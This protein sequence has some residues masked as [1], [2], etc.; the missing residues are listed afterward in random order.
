MQETMKISENGEQVDPV[1]GM[2]VDETSLHHHRHNGVDYYFCCNGC[3]EKF[4][5]DPVYYLSGAANEPQVAIPGATYICPMC[6]EVEASEP[7]SCPICG[8]ALEPD[9]AALPEM[10]TE[11]TC[12]MHPEVI[13]E[14]AGDCPICGM[15]LEARQVTVEEKN[16]ELNDMN[17]RFRVGLVL[18]LPLFLLA[19]IAD[20]APSLLPQSL[21][22]QPGQWIQFL[23]A[24]PVVLWCGLPFFER[25]WQSLKTGYYNMFTLIAIGVG[26]A[27][28]YSLFALL[29]PDLMPAALLMANGTAPVYF[30]AAAV[31]TTLVLL[32]QVLELKAR[33]QT[34]KAIRQLLGLAPAT[35]QVLLADGSEK[36][37]P[38]A[39]VG[40]GDVLRVKPGNKIPVDGN[41]TEGNSSVDES[42]ISG[43]ALPVAKTIGDS[44]IGATVNGSGSL[45]I[46]AERVGAETLL[47]QIVQM[48]SEAQRSRAPIQ[49]LADQVAAYFVPTV[50]AISV[51]TLITWALLG[52]EP[53]FSYAI[54]NAVAV[55]IIACP[56]A[57]GLAT[58]MS[59]MVGTGKGA[60]IGVLVKNAESLE[61]LQR[62]DTLVIDKTG[63]LTEGR[64]R[65]VSLQS[66]DN[67]DEDRLL[68]LAASLERASEHPLA[69][70]IVQSATDRGL[71]L[72]AVDNFESIAGR[73]VTGIVDGNTVAVGNPALMQA[74]SID[75]STILADVESGQSQGHTVMVIAI[76]DQIGGIVAMADTIKPSARP[77]L[78]SLRAE[79]LDI[80][81]MTGDNRM[82]AARV[83]AELGIERVEADVLPEQKADAIAALQALG[84]CVAMAGDGINDAPALARA[85]VGIAMGTGTD[86]AIES[87]G[88]TLL[89]GDL[90]GIL[91]ARRLSQMTMQNIRQ[92]LFFA[93]AYNS[94]GVPIAAGVL[95]PWF[96]LLLSPMLAAAAM[97]LSSVSVI[98]N[99]LRLR[100][101]SL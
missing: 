80:V 51:I 90:N 48:V 8:M 14:E 86:V 63:T 20:M 62:V 82:N 4:S 60:S 16:E 101:R 79:G 83:A 85:E 70:S 76:N 88:I 75:C 11:F 30:E 32:G 92:N 29:L 59:I 72:L 7:S 64:P 25:G 10:R 74:L 41:I 40:I 95:Y 47:S 52:P 98:G 19:M 38:L 53:S 17:R 67:F 45:L 65:L 66:Q 28:G 78:D 100:H 87:A 43:E 21:S 57:L 54:V 37:L 81:M 69:D 93:F 15:A 44:V 68:Q 23:L 97:S 2:R 34:N 31:I 35:A 12:P 71:P 50:I 33:G 6:P 27:Y 89:H 58:P 61:T 13:R 99:A 96:G 94:L 24:S 18:S 22:T 56:C 77:V 42:M 39:E 49:R 26:V 9:G 5:S 91:R 46:R 55:L 1:C 73:G 84:R 36:E 3:R